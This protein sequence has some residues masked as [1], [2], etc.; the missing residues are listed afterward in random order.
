MPRIRRAPRNFF[1]ALPPEI[2][3]GDAKRGHIT[4]LE[5]EVPLRRAYFFEVCS[6]ISTS[7]FL[8]RFVKNDLFAATR[9]FVIVV[10]PVV[11]YRAKTQRG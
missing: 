7:Y 5:N 2:G 9:G 11:E 8:R 1:G 6:N 4:Y 10:H 3:L